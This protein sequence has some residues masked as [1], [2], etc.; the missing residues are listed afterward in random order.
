MPGIPREF[1]EHAL[2]IYPNTKPVKQSLRRFSEPKCRIIGEEVTR[3]LNV[4][5]IRETK[6]A[7][8]VANPVLVRKKDTPIL[9]MCVDYG[10]V[11][12]HCPKDHF[13]CPESSRS[14]TLR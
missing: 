10:P 14:S 6:K 9:R 11:N 5:F 4:K 8:W 7:T 12:K 3:L 13:P 2:Q 1:A